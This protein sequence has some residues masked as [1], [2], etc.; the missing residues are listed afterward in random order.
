MPVVDLIKG[1]RMG[2]GTY[3]WQPSFVFPVHFADC[4][5]SAKL[6]MTALSAMHTL[7]FA[8]ARRSASDLMQREVQGLA[9]QAG[10]QQEAPGRSDDFFKRFGDRFRV[11]KRTMERPK[12]SRKRARCNDAAPADNAGNQG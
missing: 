12:V 5:D 8:A 11:L 9:V 6:Q 3:V 10:V 4:P 2:T 7:F 1:Q